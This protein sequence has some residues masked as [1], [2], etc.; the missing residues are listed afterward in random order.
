[1]TWWKL[2]R[3]I[4]KL[5]AVV[6]YKFMGAVDRSDQI[7]S[8]HTFKKNLKMVEEGIFSC[9]LSEAFLLQK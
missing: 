7:R 4:V 5:Q 2:E 9:F 1:M 8:Y 3:I 6:D